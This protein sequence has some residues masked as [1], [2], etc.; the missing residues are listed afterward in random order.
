MPASLINCQ[1]PQG[2]WESDIQN[3]SLIKQDDRGLQGG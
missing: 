1:I 3:P 2:M